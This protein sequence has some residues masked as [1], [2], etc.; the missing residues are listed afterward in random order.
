MERELSINE[1]GETANPVSLARSRLVHDRFP[2]EY[3]STSARRAINLKAVRNSNDDLWSFVMLPD[4]PLVSG[5]S[6]FSFIHSQC[7]G[8]ALTFSLFPAEGGRERH[9]V[10]PA[11]APSP[12]ARAAAAGTGASGAQEGAKEPA[13]GALGTE[14][15]AISAARAAGTLSPGDLG[16]LVVGRGRGGRERR[17]AGPP[18]RWEPAPA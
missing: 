18:E 13:V 7:I 4:A 16:V 6:P 3:T 10:R 15:R 1:M 2:L 9:A 8:V 5:L 11:H 17:G 14:G 12:S